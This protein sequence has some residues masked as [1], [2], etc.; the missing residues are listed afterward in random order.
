LT[1]TSNAVTGPAT[2]TV[3][4]SYNGAGY[5]G[6]GSAAN[7]PYYGE[8]TLTPPAN[9]GGNVSNGAAAS[10][11]I[12]PLFG[13]VDQASPYESGYASVTFTESGQEITGFATQYNPP[14]GAP[15][16]GS[17]Y[18]VDAST[19]ISDGVVASV[20]MPTYTPG[21]GI[22]FAITSGGVAGSC[23]IDLSDN[24]T[25]A[26]ADAATIS[27]TNN[28]PSDAQTLTVPSPGATHTPDARKR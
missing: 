9:Y 1:T 14:T 7:P 26:G 4:Y 5:G 10:I 12:V 28:V 15:A 17:G 3:S 6:D 25:S 23:T 24:G 18:T 8:I 19:C 22:S 2:E 20:G 16:D 27:V 21:V 11:F 13:L